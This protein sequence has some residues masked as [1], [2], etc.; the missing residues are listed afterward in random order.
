VSVELYPGADKEEVLS[1]LRKITDWVERDF[2]GM[3]LRAQQ[4][5]DPE[6][7]DAPEGQPF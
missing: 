7:L 1:L 6:E 5:D 3:Q 4:I 2:Y